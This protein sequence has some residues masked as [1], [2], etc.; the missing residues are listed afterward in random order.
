MGWYVHDEDEGEDADG[1]CEGRSG[2]G[3]KRRGRGDLTTIGI[4]PFERAIH[5]ILPA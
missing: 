2:S 5:A 3:G 4:P 1:E